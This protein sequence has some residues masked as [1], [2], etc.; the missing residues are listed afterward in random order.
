[1]RFIFALAATAVLALSALPA[2]AEYAR[3][4]SK[5]DFTSDKGTG[6]SAVLT[7]R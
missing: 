1:M 3:I 2:A 5:S 4:Q 6:D 7:L